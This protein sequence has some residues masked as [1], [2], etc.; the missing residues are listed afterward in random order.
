MIQSDKTSGLPRKSSAVSKI[1]AV[2]K[3]ASKKS[4]TSLLGRK[5]KKSNEGINKNLKNNKQASSQSKGKSMDT[6]KPTNSVKKS[7]ISDRKKSS[8]TDPKKSSN[9]GPKKSPNT[10]PKKSSNTGPKKSP[11]TG[12]KKSSNTDP[13]KSSS[14][15]RKMSSSTDRKKSSVE[16]KGSTASSRMLKE[17][18]NGAGKKNANA[19]TSK[20]ATPNTSASSATSSIRIKEHPAD[21]LKA[22][23]SASF[24]R[25]GSQQKPSTSASA[26]RTNKQNESSHSFNTLPTDKHSKQSN[27]TATPMPAVESSDKWSAVKSKSS[28]KLKHSRVGFQAPQDVSSSPSVNTG[29][30]VSA[31]ESKDSNMALISANSPS[32]PKPSPKLHKCSGRNGSK[33]KVSIT[34]EGSLRKVSS[35]HSAQGPKRFGLATVPEIRPNSVMDN[36]TDSPPDTG[37]LHLPGGQAMGDHTEALGDSEVQHEGQSLAGH[38]QDSATLGTHGNGNNQQHLGLMQK[39]R[40]MDAIDEN[41]SVVQPSKELPSIQEKLQEGT[42]TITKCTAVQ[43]E[44]HL[45]DDL[46]HSTTFEVSDASNSATRSQNDKADDDNTTATLLA[47]SPPSNKDGNT[48]PVL[49]VKI[50]TNGDADPSDDLFDP[51]TGQSIRVSKSPAG[52]ISKSPHHGKRVKSPTGRKTPISS[53]MLPTSN[54]PSSDLLI[55]PPDTGQSIQVLR[56]PGGKISKTPHCGRALESP[57]GKT[58]PI[59]SPMLPASTKPSSSDLLAEPDTGQS[60]QVS[61]SPGGRVSKSPHGTSVSESPGGMKTRTMSQ[62]L[63]A[64]T[65]PSSDTLNSVDHLIRDFPSCCLDKDQGTKH[66]IISTPCTLSRTPVLAGRET[67]QQELAELQLGCAQLHE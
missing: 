12:P 24:P 35:A 33:G 60:I 1:K 66:G 48:N 44:G 23:K 51:D 6:K 32:S 7:T 42:A 50:L 46:Q 54:K 19:K 56:S 2:I 37:P 63:P 62:M 25:K 5:D 14:H 58:T 16:L 4:R 47:T 13:K 17:A 27:R 34:S 39:T 67:P 65:K 55:E 20:K 64:S 9:T 10:G 28:R 41:H 36:P 38:Q 29:R 3:S 15:D 22:S 30:K 26:P 21:K 11:N 61:R 49:S 43:P 59:L 45:C 57:Q 53:P 40:D 52:R 8:N 31:V 18:A